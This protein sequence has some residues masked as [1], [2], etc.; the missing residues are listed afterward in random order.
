MS[1]QHIQTTQGGNV[2]DKC[3]TRRVWRWSARHAPNRHPSWLRGLTD[4][5]RR[6][7]VSRQFPHQ[8]AIDARK[9]TSASRSATQ[10]SRAS[11]SS[12]APLCPSARGT[13]HRWPHGARGAL[14]VATAALVAGWRE[15]RSPEILSPWEAAARRRRL[16]PAAAQFAQRRPTSRLSLAPPC[17][18]H[19]ALTL[20]RPSTTATVPATP[21]V[22]LSLLGHTRTRLRNCCK[23]LCLDAY[24][25]P[26]P[27]CHL[28]PHAGKRRTRGRRAASEVAP[29]C[30]AYGKNVP[31]AAHASP[32]FAEAAPLFGRL[33]WHRPQHSLVARN[34]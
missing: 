28:L 34:E 23:R 8:H 11:L 9:E 4:S 5:R 18:K 14:Q 33:S 26:Y 17:V 21:R 19:S 29:H 25:A 10:C 1:A 6:L 27:L 7:T 32:L 24:V 20:S 16:Q 22:R 13:E 31:L 12:L 30:R 3:A 2:S 15:A